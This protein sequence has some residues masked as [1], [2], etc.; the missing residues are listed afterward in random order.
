V[1][2]IPF[3][4]SSCEKRRSH[5]T[6]ER[7]LGSDANRHGSEIAGKN[8]RALVVGQDEA[9]EQIINVYQT[10]LTGL[11]PVG[12]PMGNCLFLGPTRSGKTRMVETTAE[13]L[14]GKPRAVLK[15]DC[16]EFQ[17]SHEISKLI[18]S[19]SRAFGPSRDALLSQEMVNQYHADTMKISF[20]LFDEI[21]K[22]S[23]SLWNLLLGILDKATL[24]LVPLIG[25]ERVE[26]DDPVDP[27]DE[28][29]RKSPARGSYSDA[30]DLLVQ[31]RIGRTALTLLRLLS[32]AESELRI[33][34]GGHFRSAEIAG[35]KDH[36]S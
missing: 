31:I 34:Q 36:R 22:A 15:I 21:E 25:S 35:H 32:C 10:Y 7:Y 30:C 33:H 8:L 14:A 19:A 18:G 23:D 11:A 17:H 27:V 9:I 12:R 24:T 13:S 16:A 26:R 2:I 29:R 4:E 20:V 6:N 3:R 1:K 28:F 5:G